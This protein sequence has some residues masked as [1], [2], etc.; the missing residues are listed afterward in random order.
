MC[1]SSNQMRYSSR[2][3]IGMWLSREGMRSSRMSTATSLVTSFVATNYRVMLNAYLENH[4]YVN[5]NWFCFVQP[6]RARQ[7]RR[8]HV[9]FVVGRRPYRL[10]AAQAAIAAATQPRTL[11]AH[12]SGRRSCLQPVGGRPI[13][14]FFDNTFLFT[15]ERHLWTMLM[16]FS[17]ESL[18][19]KFIDLDQQILFR[20][21]RAV[22]TIRSAT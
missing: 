5:I 19:S 14:S 16:L 7:G 8:H 15:W 1:S 13:E 6:R 9:H 2:Q 11:R 12:H 21:R 10:G 17:P 22:H 4:Q 18:Y 20:I 3:P